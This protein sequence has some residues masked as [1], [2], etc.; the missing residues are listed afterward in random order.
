M[1]GWAADPAFLV[2]DPSTRDPLL[3]PLTRANDKADWKVFVA[4]RMCYTRVCSVAGRR[5]VLLFRGH[6]D[7]C[8]PQF[9]RQL[10]VDVR[11]SAP[12]LTRGATSPHLCNTV[13]HNLHLRGSRLRPTIWRDVVHAREFATVIKVLLVRV[14]HEAL[15]ALTTIQ[16]TKQAAC[17]V[18]RLE[19]PRCGGEIMRC[20][21]SRLISCLASVDRPAS[22]DSGPA[23]R[24]WRR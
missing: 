6:R 3:A 7:T 2:H 11:S 19:R 22:A 5:H 10:A 17:R 18:G 23:K 15:K 24:V 4:S 12:A 21:D 8:K 14:G 16:C 13:T 9:S 20:K 1:A